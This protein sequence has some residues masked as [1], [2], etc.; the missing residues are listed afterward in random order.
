MV[1]GTALCFTITT[2][3]ML[4]ESATAKR[5][6][7]EFLRLLAPKRKYGGALVSRIRRHVRQK[8]LPLSAHTWYWQRAMRWIKEFGQFSVRLL[9]DEVDSGREGGR[10]DLRHLLGD[11]EMLELFISALTL[12]EV[13]FSVP[14]SARRFL[15]A[16]RM[17]LGHRSLNEIKALSDVIRGH[18]RTT[19]RTVM[20][21]ESLESDD[22]ERIADAYGC[23]K[24]WWEVQVACMISLCF[25][26][27]LRL[28]ELVVF[29]IEDVVLVLK[30]GDEKKATD[31]MT[32]PRKREVKGAF[33]HVRWRKAGQSH[34]VWIPVSCPTVMGLLL[35]QLRLLKAAGRS[36]GPLFPARVGRVA[37]SRHPTN[38]VSTTSVRNALRKALVE[39]CG[40]TRDQAKLFSGHSMRVGGSNFMRK[41]GVA[42]E[43]HRLMGGW[44]SLASSRGYFQLPVTEQFEITHKF[45][46]KERVPPKVAGARTAS[47]QAVSLLA[48]SGS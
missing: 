23:S 35:R 7:E 9:K 1:R 39:V 37:P 19:P 10:T 45:A 15:S 14:R 11:E 2:A 18:E 47:L 38:H 16:A 28:G 42:D 43:V 3:R 17:R 36:R 32:V 4:G 40:L 8:V 31:L 5:H 13:G 46:L 21:A 30:N 41:L 25:I 24:S 29:N 26:A 44:A 27:I 22:V 34:D 20:Q 33:L 48:V 12:D 6:R